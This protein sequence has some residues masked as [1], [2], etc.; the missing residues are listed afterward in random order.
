MAWKNEIELKGG[1]PREAVTVGVDADGDLALMNFEGQSVVI[2][3][4]EAQSLATWIEQNFVENESS[5]GNG[6]CCG[7]CETDH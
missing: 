4:S 7:H 3:R 2:H 6:G 5:C 1:W